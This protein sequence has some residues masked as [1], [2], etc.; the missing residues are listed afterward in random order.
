MATIAKRPAIVGGV[1]FGSVIVAVSGYL[2]W[3]LR[4]KLPADALPPLPKE[5][6]LLAFAGMDSAAWQRVIPVL[7]GLPDL[8]NPAP[9]DGAVLKLPSGTVAWVPL[10]PGSRALDNVSAEVRTAMTNVEHPL[11]HSSV[12]QSLRG[13]PTWMVL[14]QDVL[15][16]SELP[17]DKRPD[18]LGL[19]LKDGG[20]AVSWEGP[21]VTLGIASVLEPVQP[22]ALRA[23]VRSPAQLWSHG[24]GLLPAER[25]IVVTALLETLAQD[26]VS[27]A[28]SPKVDVFPLFSAAV[29][30][31]RS[32]S[33][34]VAHGV[35]AD[36]RTADAT[37]EHLHKTLSSDAKPVERI[38]AETKEGFTVDTLRRSEYPLDTVTTKKEGWTLRVTQTQEGVLLASAV[39]GTEV[40]FASDAALLESAVTHTAPATTDLLAEGLLPTK[41]LSPLVTKL[42]PE[43]PL[44][45]LLSVLQGSQQQGVLWALREKAGVWSLEAKTA[46]ASPAASR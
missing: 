7:Q 44:Y 45:K 27:D 14:T 40:V 8:P 5:H 28:V 20:A 36:P 17:A 11:N 16:F 43:L 9:K 19:T 3:D 23:F 32:D 29:T 22:D 10:T 15:P 42:L 18:A 21:S 35:V 2:V 31:E 38:T 41:D 24:K 6:T 26:L 25:T 39:R 33:G 34:T 13:E 30:V 1:I 4:L 46:L 37:L 12:M